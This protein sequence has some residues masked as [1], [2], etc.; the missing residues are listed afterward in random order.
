MDTPPKQRHRVMVQGLAPARKGAG[1]E[2]PGAPNPASP[3]RIGHGYDIHKLQPGG[4]LLLGGVEVSDQISAIAHSDGDVVIHA[5]VD[6]LLGA[7]GWGD[8]GEQFSPQ[9]DQWKN[10]ASGGFLRTIFDRVSAAGFGVV[11][12]DIT[13]MAEQ[14][15]IAP[16][17][18]QMV[19]TL[20]QI[21]GANSIIN[22]KAGT[23]EGCDAVGRGEA[24][25]AHAVV[26]LA[27]VG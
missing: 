12:A 7:M 16:F 6:A 4:K 14:P 20:R 5:L 8:I 15:K 23:N 21:L 27:L 11:N 26:L 19:Q 22:I 10:A 18:A 3:F 24:I 25:A 9:D 13:I 2:S 1:D 17:K